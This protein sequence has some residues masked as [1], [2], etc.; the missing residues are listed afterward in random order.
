[1]RRVS[2]LLS[3][4]TVGP[5]TEAANVRTLQATL[6]GLETV[7]GLPVISHFGFGSSPLPGADALVLFLGGDRSKGVCVGTADQR[8][9]V[10]LLA[11]EVVVHDGRGQSVRL[12]QTGIVVNGGGLPL[13][14]TNTPQVRMETA[15]LEVTGDVKD[16][17][18]G[19][20]ETMAAQRGVY[21]GHVHP[22]VQTGDGSTQPPQQQEK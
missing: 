3:H 5:V 19:S 18:D 8:Y 15:L 9:H 12:S 4:G 17:C 16:N 14:I 20:G 2:L 7:D 22:G 10:E 6:N 13:K 1:M 11:G 21:D